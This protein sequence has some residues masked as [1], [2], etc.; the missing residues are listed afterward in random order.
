MVDVICD[1]SL[2]EVWGVG[3]TNLDDGSTGQHLA[4]IT[5]LT[6]E[7]LKGGKNMKLQLKGKSKVQGLKEPISSSKL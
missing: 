4:L 7:A 5:Q 3:P 6:L 2:K 1:E